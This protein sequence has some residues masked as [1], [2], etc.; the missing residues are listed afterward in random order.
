VSHSRSHHPQTQGKDERFH[1]KLKAEDLHYLEPRDLLYCQQAVE[2]WRDDCHRRQASS[3]S[4]IP[5]SF[6]QR[7]T[8]RTF[9]TSDSPERRDKPTAADPDVLNEDGTRKNLNR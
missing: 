8:A 3:Q 9:F 2:R 6:D 1:R 5:R 4:E 7:E